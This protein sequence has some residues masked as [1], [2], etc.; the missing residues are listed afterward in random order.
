MALKDVEFSIR[1]IDAELYRSM[2]IR[3]HDSTAKSHE[4]GSS[5][6]T[7]DQVHQGDAG[8]NRDQIYKSYDKYSMRDHLCKDWL[9]TE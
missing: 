9:S 3:V 5:S 7:K 1:D 2:G 4:E 6:R 8:E